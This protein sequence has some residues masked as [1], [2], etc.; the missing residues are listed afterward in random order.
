MRFAF[1]RR[2]LALTVAVLGAALLAGCEVGNYPLDIFPEMHY[3]QSY[4]TQEPPMVPTPQGT[5]PT[6]GKEIPPN[7]AEAMGRENPFAGDADAV[8]TGA[9]L[10]SINCAACHGPAGDG[11]SPVARKFAAS[12]V[13]P[14]PS[15]VAAN[16]AAALSPD[17]FIYGVIT[18]GIGNMPALWKILAP[19]ERWAI[20]TYLRTIRA[21][22]TP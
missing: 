13:R 14:P 8:L 18:N 12:G 7:L 3:Q 17:G 10:F 22:T 2:F 6:T 5:V 21:P 19:D 1:R 15:L 16:S 4:R 11:N 20:I 9:K